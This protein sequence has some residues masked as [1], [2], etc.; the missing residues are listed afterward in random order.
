V[1]PHEVLGVRPD[2]SRAEIRAAYR[3]LVQIFHPDRHADS[4]EAVR[5]VAAREM[6]LLNDAYAT[7]TARGARKSTAASTKSTAAREAPTRKT[8]TRPTAGGRRYVSGAG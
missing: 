8:S 4:T 1:T 5:M 6:K 3:V 2:A 7:L